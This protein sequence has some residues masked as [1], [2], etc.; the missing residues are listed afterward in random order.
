MSVDVGR[1]CKALVMQYMNESPYCIILKVTEL[2]LLFEEPGVDVR[3]DTLRLSVAIK[4]LGFVFVGFGHLSFTTSVIIV[5]R[6]QP[7][8]IK[9]KD[10]FSTGCRVSFGGSVPNVCFDDRWFPL[11]LLTIPTIGEVCCKLPAMRVVCCDTNE[12][13]NVVALF[14]AITRSISSY[15]VRKKDAHTLKVPS[16][17]DLR[18]ELDLARSNTGM[19]RLWMCGTQKTDRNMVRVQRSS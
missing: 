14:N 7:R 17:K 1:D 4:V 8:Y 16:L 9:L 3:K 13:L 15:T 2:E 12:N 11:V 6:I 10:L 5:S 18:K 19:P